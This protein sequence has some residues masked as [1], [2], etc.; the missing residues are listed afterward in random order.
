MYAYQSGN[1]DWNPPA[2]GKPWKDYN[3]QSL[4]GNTGICGKTQLFD[5]PA[6]QYDYSEYKDSAGNP[7][8]W[9]TQETYSKG[10]IIDVTIMLTAEHC[11]FFEMKGCP[12]GRD[13]TQECFDSYP[14]E[15]IE[16]V[17]TSN[18][19]MPKDPNHPYRAHF[20]KGGT[21]KPLQY[22]FKLP[23]DLVG[24]EVLLQWV[25]WT[26]NSCWLE[27]YDQ[28]ITEISGKPSSDYCMAAGQCPPRESIPWIRDPNFANSQV[29]EL[30][31][32]CA[33]VTIT[34]DAS[35]PVAPAPTPV[36]PAPTPIVPA[37]IASPVA[38]PTAQ[39][40]ANPT[41]PPLPTIDGNNTGGEPSCPPGYSGF[42]AWDEC[43]MYYQCSNGSPLTPQSCPSGL[44]FNTNINACDW[45]YNVNCSTSGRRRH[46]RNSVRSF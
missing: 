38:D 6:V 2:A 18:P 33:E 7:M 23:D 25:Y 20:A 21:Y 11:G 26:G 16:D 46:L 12:N 4:N 44:L 8:P 1:G 17:T 29:P 35:A 3:Y 43:K 22:K 34:G 31:W 24:P 41:A 39:P 5:P 15:F 28:Y 37:P 9:I 30:F 14:L 13:S 42:M 32:N 45:D 27:G 40:A 19:T 36:V 10:Q